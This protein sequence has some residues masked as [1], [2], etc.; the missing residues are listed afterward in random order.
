MNTGSNGSGTASRRNLLLGGSGL[1]AAALVGAPGPWSARAAAGGRSSAAADGS[2]ARVPGCG[3]PWEAGASRDS[4]RKAYRFLAEKFDQYG[5]GSHLRVPR[6]YTGGFFTQPDFDFV[7]SFVYDD[8]LVIQAWLAGGSAA[9][10]HRATILG[11]TLLYAQQHDPNGDGRTRASY[12]PDSFF[13]LDGKLDIGSPAAYTGNQAWVGMT[14][15]RLYAVTRHPRFLTGALRLA[16]WI[17]DNTFDGAHAPYG[18]TGGRDA[19][20]NPNTYKATEHNIDTGAFFTMLARL[21]G[22]QVWR[23]RATVAFSF[24]QAMQDAATGHLW[25]GTNPDG[26]TTNYYPVPED[27]QSWAFLATLDHRYSPDL[28]WVLDHLAATDAGISGV[29]FSNADTSKVWLEGTAHL[30]LALRKRRRGRDVSSSRWLLWNIQ[31]AQRSAANGDGHGVVAASSDGLDTGFGDL[32]YQS[33]H[34]GTTAWYLL[35]AQNANPFR[36]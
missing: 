4:V 33:L 31:K 13:T 7:S 24:V 34:T 8:A 28:N 21:T 15:A 16:H 26:T 29:S 5:S 17:Q 18:Y 20:D 2:A 25:T 36:L 12:Q 22:D 11:D 30:A 6:S 14:F 3:G 35:A 23:R 19:Q 9:D 27:V 1:M 10:R 32:Y